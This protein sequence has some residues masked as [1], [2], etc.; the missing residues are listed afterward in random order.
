MDWQ[1]KRQSGH[2]EDRRDEGAIGAL[3]RALGADVPSTYEAVNRS[4][5]GDRLPT[6]SPRQS[7]P[8]DRRDPI[9]EML[10]EILRGGIHE[11]R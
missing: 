11:T 4:R 2:I 10:D 9:G 8:A 5:K 3:I 1:G 6:P 7:K